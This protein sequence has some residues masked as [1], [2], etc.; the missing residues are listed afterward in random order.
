MNK[1]NNVYVI[2]YASIMV[3]LV[4]IG[5]AFTSQSLKEKQKDNENIDQMRQILSA[6]H[7][8]ATSDNA[9]EL[10][11]TTITNAYMVDANGGI[12]EGTEG[13]DVKAPAFTASLSS[14]KD[15]GKYPVF[16]ANVDGAKKYVLGMYGTGL[17]GPIWGYI[18]LDED[19]NTVFGTNFS[20]QGET[21]G[22]GAEIVSPS[23]N[24]QFPGK[25][26]YRD[27]EFRSI[28]VVKPGKSASDRDYVDGIS[29]GTLTSNGVHAMLYDALKLYAPF[30]DTQKN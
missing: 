13:T 27:G 8:Q 29:G 18:S 15:A 1:N 30:L 11:K 3:I 25:K 24:N 20:H 4:A 17:W 7:I 9:Q 21:P 23:F 16:E 10:Y 6:L 12:V 5:L 26:L 19:A 2:L 22:L 28:A 14:L